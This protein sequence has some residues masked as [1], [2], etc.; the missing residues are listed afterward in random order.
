MNEPLLG[1]HVAQVKAG[2][3]VLR[4]HAAYATR[5][6]VWDGAES[7]LVA[8][9]ELERQLADER[10]RTDCA[11]R[12]GWLSEDLECAGEDGP[13]CWKHLLAEAQGKLDA[14]GIWDKSTHCCQSCAKRWLARILKEE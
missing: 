11:T 7:A 2:L 9:A 14:V 5:D 6:D 10:A 8:I 1:E 13:A 4:G 12:G 3:E